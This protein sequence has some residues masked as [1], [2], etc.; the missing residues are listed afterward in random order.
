M[1]FD[2]RS[3]EL[4]H[5]KY[6]PDNPKEVISG[7]GGGLRKSVEDLSSAKAPYSQTLETKINFL[8]KVNITLEEELEK[9]KAANKKLKA[10]IRSLVEKI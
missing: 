7:S 5:T 10:I 8:E 6:P 9:T 2:D 3:N 4:G 1:I